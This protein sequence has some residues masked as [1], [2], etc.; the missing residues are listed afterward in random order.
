AVAFRLA[1]P[2]GAALLVPVHLNGQG[3]MEFVFDTGPTVTCVDASVA[4]ALALPEVVAGSGVAIGA[5]GAGR[6]RLV[7]VDSMRTGT[8]NDLLAGVTDLD[9]LRAIGPGVRG[10]VGLN[11][12]KPFHVTLDFRAEQV[13]CT[14]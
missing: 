3:P 4:K 5:R 11:F 14:E 12:M 9:V 10:L 8:A 6:V 2:N 1:G 7:R 13:T